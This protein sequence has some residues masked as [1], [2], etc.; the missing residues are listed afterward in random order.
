MRRLLTFAVLALAL[1]LPAGAAARLNGPDDGTLSVKD[2]RGIVTIQ[3]RGAVIG[4]FGKGQVTINDPV[5]GDGTGPI[6]TGDEWSKDKSETASV[7]GGTR[8]R[9]RIIGGTFRIV[10]R[11]RGINLS[12]VGRGNI[13]LN[14]QGTEDDGSY[15]TNGGDYNLIPAFA[16]P[17]ALSATS[18]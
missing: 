15:A 11:G 8:V 6:V 17:F 16:L 12:F 7:W 3:G 1:A 10:V 2:T 18:P 4:S 9:F 5:D 14:G 13:I